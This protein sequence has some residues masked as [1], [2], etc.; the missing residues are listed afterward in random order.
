[1]PPLP[2]APAVAD[3]AV[4]LEQTQQ[5]LEAAPRLAFEK[6]SL[7]REPVLRERLRRDAF[8][9][10]TRTQ[11]KVSPSALPSPSRSSSTRADR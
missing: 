8:L 7:L 1:M 4:L 6:A 10:L 3:Q 11:P 9:A 5:L 2:P